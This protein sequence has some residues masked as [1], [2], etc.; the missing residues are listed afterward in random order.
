MTQHIEPAS[1]RATGRVRLT[2]ELECDTEPA[3]GSILHQSGQRDDFASLLE[4]ILLLESARARG[5]RSTDA[6]ASYA[7]PS[8]SHWG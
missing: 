7:P 2:V 3:A 8:T 1:N 6:A 4:L 5:G